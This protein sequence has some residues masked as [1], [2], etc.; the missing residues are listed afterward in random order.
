M[1]PPPFDAATIAA[2]DVNT[3]T[4]FGNDNGSIMIGDGTQAGGIAVGSRSGSTNIFGYD[5]SLQA[6]NGGDGRFAQIGFQVSDGVAL[7]GTD[8][9]PTSPRWIECRRD[10]RDLR[11]GPRCHLPRPVGDAADYQ[12]N[13]AQIGHVG[14]EKASGSTVEAA[15][16]ATLEI[17]AVGDVTFTG[18]SSGNNNAYAQLGSRRKFSQR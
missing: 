9:D 11:S 12:Y 3:T 4:L 18:G 2:A 6:G 8:L 13:Y 16:D 7:D 1:E 10:R 17:A 15:V 5:V 14:A